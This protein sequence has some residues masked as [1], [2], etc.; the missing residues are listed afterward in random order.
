[1]HLYSWLRVHGGTEDLR[2][3]SE[4]GFSD[5]ERDHSGKCML[6]LVPM[7]HKLFSTACFIMLEC[8]LLET[9]KTNKGC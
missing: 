6:H 5:I 3:Q 8:L 9:K 7:L 1:M 4:I 2:G